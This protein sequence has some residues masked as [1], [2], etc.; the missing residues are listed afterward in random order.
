MTKP[1]LLRAARISLEPE[2]DASLEAD[3]WFYPFIE[4]R[5]PDWIVIAPGFSRELR[6]R[7]AES[8]T[9]VNAA[10]NLVV[11]WHQDAPFTVNL[12]E[13]I[14]W[15][16]LT[17]DSGSVNELLGSLLSIISDD[18]ETNLGLVR[19]FA[20]AIPY[21]PIEASEAAN[22][23][24]LALVASGLLGGRRYVENPSGD[25]QWFT[26]LAGFLPKSV[27]KMGYW[28]Q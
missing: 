14:I 8:E 16:A 18:P 17:S 1:Q 28:V 10:R 9:R 23:S 3:F 7:L 22:F 15:P 5:T 2:A 27:P 24:V 4:S 20:G 26:T 13:K 12:E 19:W 21:F 11:E 25:T 6:T